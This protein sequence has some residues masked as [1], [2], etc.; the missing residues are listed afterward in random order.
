[1][2]ITQIILGL[3]F[4]LG[5]VISLFVIPYIKTHMTAEQITILTGIAQTVVYAAEKIFGAKMGADKLAYALKVAK[6]LLAKKGLSFDEDVVRA[7]I[8]AQVQ[9]LTIEKTT[10]ETP[11]VTL[12]VPE[13]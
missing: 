8:E 12:S 5:S 10:A 2:N 11:A 6:D 3:I 1:M 7:A 13:K 4:I 9:Q